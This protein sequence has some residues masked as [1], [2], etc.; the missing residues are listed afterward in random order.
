MATVRLGSDNFQEVISSS[1]IVLVDFWASWCGP[2]QQFAPVFEKAS[3]EHL[4]V[5]FAKVDTE[6]EQQLA[7]EFGIRSIPT[8]MVLRD[9]IVLYVQP[10][11]LS[12][13]AIAGLLTQVRDLDMDEVRGK[14]ARR[15]AEATA[16]M[17]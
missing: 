14:V 8:L 15:A 3:E 13:A 11:G 2:C 4:D 9:K 12:A 10:G 5:V 6:V 17:A 7:T 1:D 16:S